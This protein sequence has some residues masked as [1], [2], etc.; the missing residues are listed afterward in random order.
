M[1]HLQW[2]LLIRHGYIFLLFHE[3]ISKRNELN[4][5]YLESRSFYVITFI[6]FHEEECNFSSHNGLNQSKQK[7]LLSASETF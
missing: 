2:A 6:S 4:L 3:E 5:L 7:Q 1:S